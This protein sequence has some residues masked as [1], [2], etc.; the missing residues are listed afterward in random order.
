[1]WKNS[2]FPSSL[3]RSGPRSTGPERFNL[4]WL[5]DRVGATCDPGTVQATLAELTASAIAASI[6]DGD[7]APAALF[8]CGGGARNTDLMR[9]LHRRLQPRGVRLGTTD[10][11]GLAAEWVEASAFAWLAAQTLHHLPGNAPA[12]TG[13]AGPRILGGIYAAG[14]GPAAG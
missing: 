8:V 1:M 6:P 7:A 9:R 13:A 5:N 4:Q 11:L 12:V 3:T 10:E 2:A 14:A